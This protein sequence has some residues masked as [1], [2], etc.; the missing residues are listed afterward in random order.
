MEIII[1]SISLAFLIALWIQRI[2]VKQVTNEFLTN[3]NKTIEQSAKERENIYKLIKAENLAEFEITRPAPIKEPRKP[4][5][6]ELRWNYEYDH[7][8]ESDTRDLDGTTQY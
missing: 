2:T 5:P 8:G 4:S 1:G 6:D 7:V 3:L